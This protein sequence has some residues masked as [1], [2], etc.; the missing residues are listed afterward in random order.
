MDRALVVRKEEELVLN[1]RFARRAAELVLSVG[2]S[3]LRPI[4]KPEG[5]DSGSNRANGC[6]IV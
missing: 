2:V 1:N 3:T 4:H 5:E 6:V